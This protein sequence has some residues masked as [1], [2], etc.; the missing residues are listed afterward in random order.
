MH[1]E[2]QAVFA[3][4]RDQVQAGT[5]P[6]QQRFVALD[7]AHFKRR[8]QATVGQCMPVV[9]KPGRLGHPQNDLQIAQ[10]ARRFLAVGLQ[11][12]GRIFELG[13]ALAQFQRLGDKEGPRVHGL[14]KRSLELLHQFG[15]AGDQ[16]VL[17]QG[18]LYSDVFGCLGQ[19]V[20]QGAHAGANFQPHIPAA[21]DKCLDTG[22]ERGVVVRVEPVRQQHQHID[23]GVREQLATAKATN[24]QQSERVLQAGMFPKLFEY[25]IGEVRQSA[26]CLANVAPGGI[27][28][29]QVLQQEAFVGAVGVADSLQISHWGC[30]A[31]ASGCHGLCR[32]KGRNGR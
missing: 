15:I 19:A 3:S 29:P 25:A 2:D 24:G 20:A 7:L 12:V 13:V 1:V 5:H 21:A 17:Q 10:T 14:E 28:L 26:Q 11:G 23:V 22:L 8:G 18:G 9:T 4:T 32:H 30:R 27:A 31:R 16:P 6:H